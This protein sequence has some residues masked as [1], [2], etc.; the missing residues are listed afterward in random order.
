MK[1]SLEVLQRALAAWA[2]EFQEA[3][4]HGEDAEINF[5]DVIPEQWAEQAAPYLLAL[6]ERCGPE[7]ETPDGGEIDVTDLTK[8]RR[9]LLDP[10]T[11]K[12][13]DGGPVTWGGP[14]KKIERRDPQ[15]GAWVEHEFD[16][17][18]RGDVFRIIEGAQGGE[19]PG[20]FI[21]DSDARP[22]AG[23]ADN[24]D[25]LVRPEVT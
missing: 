20:P 13:R 8:T 1:V 14:F 23:S 21:C 2:R 5:R 16:A 11:G 18:K 12:V 10:G 3:E 4:R 25:L 6:I 17:L 24:F 9:Q 7:T 15:T 22:V 19:S